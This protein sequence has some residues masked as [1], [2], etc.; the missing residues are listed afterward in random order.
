M[1]HL[2]ANDEFKNIFNEFLVADFIMG[3]FSPS[4]KTIGCPDI[5][6]GQAI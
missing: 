4:S 1:R 6:S 3:F 5:A 2:A